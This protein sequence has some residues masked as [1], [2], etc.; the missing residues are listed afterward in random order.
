MISRDAQYDLNEYH[1]GSAG[2]GTTIAD[3]CIV[4]RGKYEAY[5]EYVVSYYVDRWAN[6]GGSN[7]QDLLNVT[8]D[9]KNSSLDAARFSLSLPTLSREHARNRYNLSTAGPQKVNSTEKTEYKD[10]YYKVMTAMASETTLMTIT[11]ITQ[12]DKS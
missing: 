7:N 10:G 1:V 6:L 8:I 5:V 11:L 9:G 3:Y 4:P 2:E 12:Q